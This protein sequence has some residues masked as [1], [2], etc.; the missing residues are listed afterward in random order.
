MAD[1]KAIP[2]SQL[3]IDASSPEPPDHLIVSPSVPES[4]T[5]QT[6]DDYPANASPEPPHKQQSNNTNNNNNNSHS[7]KNSYSYSESQMTNFWKL[8]EAEKRKT[9]GYAS[10]SLARPDN[11]PPII[12]PTTI[13]EEDERDQEEFERIRMDCM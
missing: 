3:R 8:Q 2:K 1:S 9:G 10:H 4:I 13:D 6:D 11:L 7:R 5:S 12:P